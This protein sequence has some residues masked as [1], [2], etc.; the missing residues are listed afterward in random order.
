MQHIRRLILL[1]L[2][3][4]VACAPGAAKVGPFD[5][6][7][8]H[9]TD[10][11][12]AAS[13]VD[14]FGVR[15]ICPTLPGGREWY[16][17]STADVADAE[18]KPKKH[19]AKTAEP[20][21]F[22]I[23][24]CPHNDV[25]SPSGKAWWRN[26]EMTAYL[27]FLADL[28]APADGSCNQRP[29]W[30]F[31]ARGERHSPEIF[32][33]PASIDEGVTAPPGTATWPGYPFSGPSVNARCLGTSLKGLL[34]SDSG[35]V[36]FQKEI[37]HVAGYTQETVLG[38]GLP[39]GAAPGAWFGYKV[40]LRNFHGDGA[41]HMETWVDPVAT[42]AWAR[43]FEVDD[44][45]GWPAKPLPGGQPALNGCDGAPF[46]Y[47]EDQLITWAG[48]HVTFRADNLAYDLRSASVREVEPLP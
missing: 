45:G 9:P 13:G 6:G 44:S 39:G 36:S 28:P 40:I 22:R 14:G 8:L 23:S 12:C 3:G 1:G 29:H 2:V 11:T 41:V 33:D 7:S 16:L 10:S 30:T 31:Y 32:A 48:P 25:V 17:P 5:G 21:V 27:R 37:S 26:V 47:A 18:W 34:F 24:G 20:G 43:V 15:K 38:S 35:A 46:H 4:A 42:G 19:I